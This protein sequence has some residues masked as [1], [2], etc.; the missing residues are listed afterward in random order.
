VDSLEDCK[1]FMQQI[2]PCGACFNESLFKYYNPPWN[3]FG[4]LNF[5]LTAN[6]DANYCSIED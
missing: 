4:R 3:L 5:F 1:F 6:K 2:K